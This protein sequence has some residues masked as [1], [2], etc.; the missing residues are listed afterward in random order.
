MK[1]FSEIMFGRCLTFDAVYICT[2]NIG[3]VLAHIPKMLEHF[4]CDCT[5]SPLSFCVHKIGQGQPKSSFEQIMM[6][7]SPGC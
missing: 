5:V 2:R 7:S 4:K 6:D 3:I 1:N